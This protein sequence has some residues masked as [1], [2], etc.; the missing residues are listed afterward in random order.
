MLPNSM[1]DSDVFVIVI[2]QQSSSPTRVYVSISEKSCIPCGSEETFKYCMLPDDWMHYEKT[3]GHYILYL[4]I[5]GA[6]HLCVDDEKYSFYPGDVF[7]M[8]PN[9]HHS[10]FKQSAVT[11]Y[12]IHF[13]MQN[14]QIIDCPNYEIALQTAHER[15]KL[16]LPM[17]FKL[18]HIENTIILINQLMTNSEIA[19]C[20]ARMLSG[21]N[22]CDIPHLNQH[23]LHHPT[24]QQAWTTRN[25]VISFVCEDYLSSQAQNIRCAKP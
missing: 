11:F 22:G 12:W 14:V 5:S 2:F 23:F 25:L 7:L 24:F 19:T 8:K 4:T 10:G 17:H 21:K 18:P 9:A 15:G 16:L 13:Q 3:A 20:H 6:F 1:F